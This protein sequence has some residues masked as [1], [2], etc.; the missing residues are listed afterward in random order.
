MPSPHGCIARLKLTRKRAL[1]L[2]TQEIGRNVTEILQADAS[3][4]LSTS[5]FLWQPGLATP[6]AILFGFAAA[7]GGDGFVSGVG[8]E[9]V[10]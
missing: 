8:P 2:C 1:C 4:S 9:Q 10:V 7:L 3:G 6:I 5:G